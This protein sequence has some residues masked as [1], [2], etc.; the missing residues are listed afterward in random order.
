MVNINSLERDG[1]RQAELCPRHT[2]MMSLTRALLIP[3]K[4]GITNY[5][6]ARMSE[7]IIPG[8]SEQTPTAFASVKYK[9]GLC[10]KFICK[11]ICI[12]IFSNYIGHDSSR[13]ENSSNTPLQLLVCK[14]TKKIY[15]CIKQSRY[16]AL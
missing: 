10:P 2:M 4:A 1:L 8:Q 11:C 12:N 14:C 15:I 5:V 13:G 7:L 16:S 9:T 3:H 6:I